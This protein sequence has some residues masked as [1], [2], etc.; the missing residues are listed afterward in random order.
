MLESMAG[1]KSGT[2]DALTGFTRPLTGAYYVIPSG[3]A[4]RA[5]APPS[6]DA[7]V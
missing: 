5:V 2:R 7:A 3:D 4:L 6:G 1:L